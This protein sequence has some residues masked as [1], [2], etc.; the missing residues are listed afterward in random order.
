[1]G[2][3]TRLH[4]DDSQ[5]IFKRPITLCRTCEYALYITE[6]PGEEVEVMLLKRSKRRLPERLLSEYQ[7]FPASG[8]RPCA[9]HSD[10]TDLA[11]PA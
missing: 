2:Y 9:G 3:Y 6:A 11:E 8:E 10:Y 4:A 5:R 1:M 7:F